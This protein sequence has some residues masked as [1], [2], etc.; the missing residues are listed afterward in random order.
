MNC[1]DAK[2]LLDSFADGELDLVNHVQVEAHVDECLRCD[3]IYRNRAVLKNAFAAEILYFRAPSELRSRIR[4]SLSE[5]ETR[6]QITRVLEW[7]WKPAFVYA[8]ILTAV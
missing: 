1:E 3:H 6:S 8:W 2:P 7:R 5:S 4:L